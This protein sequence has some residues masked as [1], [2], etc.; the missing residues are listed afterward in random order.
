VLLGLGVL[1]LAAAAA[2]GVWLR[3]GLNSGVGA[4]SESAVVATPDVP[5]VHVGKGRQTSAPFHLTGGTYRSVWSAWG[6]AADFPPC[7]H[8]VQ[9]M[10]VDPA[11]GDA[12]NGHVVD[13]VKVESIPATGASAEIY[14]INIKPGDYYLN[15]VSACA[16]QVELSPT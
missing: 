10:A 1:V 16:W 7:A 14:L 12:S 15:V 6:E 8:L 9:L 13:L 3:T 11:N 4:P 2:V 5:V